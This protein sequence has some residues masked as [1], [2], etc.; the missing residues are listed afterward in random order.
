MPAKSSS[1][2][3]MTVALTALF[4][5]VPAAS[6]IAVMLR[7]AWAVCSWIVVPTSLPVSGEYGAV[8]DTNT[9][10][11]AFTAWLKYGDALGRASDEIIVGDMYSSGVDWSDKV[12]VVNAVMSTS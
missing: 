8:P 7:S 2:A 6:K 11:P 1:S 12:T 4:R 5:L 10:P 3:R 9:K